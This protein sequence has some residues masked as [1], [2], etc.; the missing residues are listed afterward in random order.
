[1]QLADNRNNVKALSI[2]AS[3][4]VKKKD[5]EA[6]LEDY[7]RAIG[8]RGDDVD[9]N[10]FY[11]RGICNEKLGMLDEAIEDFSRVLELNPNHFNAAYARGS[12]HNRKG[13]FAQAID[14]Y[15]FALS[16]DKKLEGSSPFGPLGSPGLHRKG[17][18]LVGAS[19]YVS[20]REREVR[21]RLEQG[22]APRP[23]VVVSA[24]SDLPEG[25]EALRFLSSTGALSPSLHSR[26]PD[27]ELSPGSLHGR[28]STPDLESKSASVP[29]ALA[30]PP[31]GRS[32][33][34]VV[35]IDASS[36]SS[37]PELRISTMGPDAG[38]VSA[39]TPT[40]GAATPF[41][42]P[43]RV[44]PGLSSSRGPTPQLTTPGMPPSMTPSRTDTP[45]N[46]GP[47][48]S[49]IPDTMAFVSESASPPG[50]E[51]GGD[52]EGEPDPS[53]A[54]GWHARGFECRKRGDFRGAISAYTKALTSNPQHFKALFNRA[55]AHDKL[56]DFRQ[57][58]S[59]Y[60]HAIAIDS[61]NA[62]AFYNRGISR[63]RAGDYHEA[64]ADFSAA[65]ELLP[66]NADFFHNRGFVYRK[67]GD[68][69][70]AVAD[71]SA[72]LRINP[73][74]FK[75]VYNRCVSWLMLVACSTDDSCRAYSYE[76][77]NR[78]HEA[79]SD[80]TSACELAPT[81]ANAWHNKAAVLDKLARSEDAVRDFSRALELDGESA[82]SF[83]SRGLA[84][85]KLG[86]RDEALA[87]LNMA[88]EI[89]SSNPV[90]RYNRGYFFRNA[91]KFHEAAEDFRV[92]LSVDPSNLSALSNLGYACR[93]LAQFPEAA[94]CYS[95]AL[96]LEPDN[97]K[98]LNNRAYAL[99]KAG[100][101][102]LAVGDYT[103][104]VE[105]EPGNSHALHNRGLC[106]DKLGSFDKAI[107][108]FT[109]V[110]ELDSTN[111]SAFFSRGAVHDALGAYDKALL[112]YTQ[113]LRLDK[114]QGDGPGDV[115]T[116]SVT[117][118]P[119][120]TSRGDLPD[121]IVP[122]EFASSRVGGSR[123]PP[124]RATPA[125]R[126]RGAQPIADASRSRAVASLSGVKAS[127]G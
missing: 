78:L 53:D 91:G 102:D 126:P 52:L 117:T 73:S 84:L 22:I 11:Q 36:S 15:N 111:A 100:R 65:I 19:E 20:Q 1:L 103:R 112:D 110:L 90:F 69:A 45:T 9:A 14:D 27:S 39:V 71:Y 121:S 54:D 16:K 4:Y 83:N 59:D 109:R 37:R 5:Y 106:F 125:A 85:V 41:R 76:K 97:V 74:H 82:S 6:A 79:L 104:V 25:S 122:P 48:A 10:S 51:T 38:P 67:L 17:S 89:E 26:A 21:E 108:D 123:P 101:Y 66:S 115:D 24:L 7:N 68:F 93:K 23:E 96:R 116:I 46:R 92:C 119:A 86:L 81:N 63:D 60:T 113:A 47:R 40:A 57:A 56:G 28:H 29:G 2:R 12:C 55:F 44:I 30:S 61:A 127:R 34:R 95:R 18:F 3:C 43:A 62:Y 64:L 88:V 80:Y 107:A 114:E 105:L 72:A 124:G 58:I 35:G 75:S 8:L 50:S 87:D 70:S 32:P 77:M 31:R 118:G 33:P 98:L 99:A 49:P 42:I 120:P 13:N 94:A